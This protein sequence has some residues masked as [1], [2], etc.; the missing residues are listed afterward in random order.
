VMHE[1][2]LITV[3]SPTEIKRAYSPVRTVEA[4]FDRALTAAEDGKLRD[5]LARDAE[6]LTVVESRGDLIVFRARN[7]EVLVAAVVRWADASGIALERV[8]VSE[9]SLEDAFVSLVS[10]QPEPTVGLARPSP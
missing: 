1:G 7:A 8:A 3:G 6:A 4:E 10:G 9:S 2:H 5:L